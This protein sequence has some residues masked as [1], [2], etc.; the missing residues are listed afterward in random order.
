VTRYGCFWHAPATHF[1]L[2]AHFFLQAPQLASSLVKSTHW[3][4][5]AVFAGSQALV[6]TPRT[7]VVSGPP[8]QGLL[9][10]PQLAASEVTSTHAAPHFMN[11]GAQVKPHVPALHVGV[12]PAGALQTVP[13]APQ[14]STS[15]LTATQAPPPQSF[16]SGLHVAVQTPFEQIC[17][18]VQ[19]LPQ[20]PQSVALVLVLTQVPA[21]SV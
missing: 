14:L 13:H 6:H 20:A 19:A 2:S 18:A 1:C 8:L 11:P 17:P 10:A 3:S 9:Q 16:V 4:S 15:D 7:H 12:A 5:Q 21:Q